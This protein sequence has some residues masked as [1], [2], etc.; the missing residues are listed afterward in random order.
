MKSP[1]VKRI[2]LSLALGIALGAAI[3]EIAF[4]LLQ[5]TARPPQEIELVIPSGTAERVRRGEDSPALPDSMSFVVGDT[6]I[7]RNDDGEDHQLGPL[8]IPAGSAARLELST[9]DRYAFT[10]S[11]RADQYLGLDVKEPLT[12]ATRLEGIFFS[13]VPLGVL[14]AL[15][16]VVLDPRRHTAIHGG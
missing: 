6:L 16:S 12:W 1:I 7:V 10:C 14:L 5:E 13:G 15:Y 11:F 2:L 4:Y 8:W 3:S 9:I